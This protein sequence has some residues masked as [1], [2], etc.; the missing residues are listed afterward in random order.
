LTPN[1]HP[2]ATG[3]KYFLHHSVHVE[4]LDA[5]CET[6]AERTVERRE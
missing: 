5:I 2:N 6:I 4:Q 3:T 1:M